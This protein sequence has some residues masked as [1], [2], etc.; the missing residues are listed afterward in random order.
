MMENEVETQTPQT[1]EISPEREAELKAHEENLTP[2]PK[3]A[4][5]KQRGEDAIASQEAQLEA[6]AITSGETTIDDAPVLNEGLMAESETPKRSRRGR[7]GSRRNDAD[8][9]NE[10]TTAVETPTEVTEPVVEVKAP[11]TKTTS[12]A[13]TSEAPKEDKP[14]RARR[15]RG[16]PRK[17]EVA[18]DDTV[19]ESPTA[20]E[21][22]AKAQP[23]SAEVAETNDKEEEPKKKPAPRGRKPKAKA[24]NAP[25]EVAAAEP[26]QTVTEVVATERSA[27]A[28]V[29]E[30]SDKPKRGRGRG[31]RRAPEAATED[32]AAPSVSDLKA[33]LLE[34][35]VDAGTTAATGDAEKPKRGRGRVR[36]RKADTEAQ[37][38][39]SAQQETT[40]TE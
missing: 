34:D 39:D 22:S 26:T 12:E 3:R 15:G 23:E 7:R 18:A 32:T 36:P 16:R 13:E 20:V 29:E 4:E 8:G 37:A 24:D 19:A 14:Q 11:E 2:R 35:G 1:L 25:A 10:T 28:T 17:S 6:H 27:E 9:V 21:N 33:Q 40:E 5:R 30:G 38:T 31:R